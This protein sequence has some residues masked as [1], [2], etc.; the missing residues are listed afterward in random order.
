MKKNKVPI[1]SLLV[2]ALLMVISGC[3]S[4]AKE[5]MPKKPQTTTQNQIEKE[6]DP[7]FKTEQTP[8]K[9]D[10]LHKIKWGDTL[11]DL[12]KKYYGKS[13]KW[14]V[15][16][17]HNNF[18]NNTV[19]K[20][21]QIIQ[22]P[23]LDGKEYR[24]N[25]TQIKSVTKKFDRDYIKHSIKPGETLSDVAKIYYDSYSKW[26]ILAKFNGL[27]K[28]TQL[29]VDQIVKVPKIEGMMLTDKSKKRNT[30]ASGSP[31]KDYKYT[32]HTIGKGD[33][34]ETIAQKYYGQKSKWPIIAE[35]NNLN[36]KSKLSIDQQIKVRIIDEQDQQS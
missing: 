31:N 6:I 21:G 11:S 33:T 35:D 27:R 32:T 3:V 29:K 10:I 17:E 28:N 36:N 7:V 22:I 12:A 14:R 20:V 8:E 26:R 19:L 13:N 34:L 18:E 16:A 23:M 24:V 25:T 30:V 4:T 1:L 2:P 15:I 5:S 9:K